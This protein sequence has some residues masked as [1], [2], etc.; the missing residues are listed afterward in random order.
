M[1]NSDTMAMRWMRFQN[2]LYARLSQ[3]R[4]AARGFAGQPE[5][6]TVGSFARGRQLVAGNLLFAGFLVEA[7]D[8]DLWDVAAPNAAFDDERHGFAWL[9]D[10][11]AV[12]DARA[13]ERPS[14]GSGGGS[15]P[16]ARGRGRGG[17]R[18]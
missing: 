4:K 5:P 7:Q 13:R 6:R 15:R 11:A 3:R 17:P 18:T 14:A 8:T 2:R 9:D 10:L 1:S 16:M 12:G